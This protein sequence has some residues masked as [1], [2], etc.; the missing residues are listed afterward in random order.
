MKKLLAL[1]LL[2]P[3]LGVSQTVL[4]CLYI[5]DSYARI[6]LIIDNDYSARE[7]IEN[8]T[9][10]IKYSVQT[11][12]ETYILYINGGARQWYIDRYT[13]DALITDS[14]G[15]RAQYQCRVSGKKF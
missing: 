11:T 14:G 15:T 8:S 3:S 7:L 6:T 1:L 4:D 12:P 5:G 2:I 13:G 10:S 9:S